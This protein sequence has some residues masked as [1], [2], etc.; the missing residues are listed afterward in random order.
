ML[1]QLFWYNHHLPHPGYVIIS[2][3]G[4]FRVYLLLLSRVLVKLDLFNVS[5]YLVPQVRVSHHLLCNEKLSSENLRIADLS[6]PDGLVNADLD[7]G[8][9]LVPVEFF[10]QKFYYILI[11]LLPLGHI[12]SGCEEFVCFHFFQGSYSVL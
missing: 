3:I 11:F 6:L 12:E 5:P 7:L 4:I 10:P 9:S 2:C 8:V 1:N